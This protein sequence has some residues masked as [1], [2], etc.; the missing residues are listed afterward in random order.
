VPVRHTTRRGLSS[1]VVL[2]VVPFAVVSCADSGSPQSG[3]RPSPTRTHGSTAPSTT[4]TSSGTQEVTF[5][6]YSPQGALLGAF[7]VTQ[8]VSGSCITPG[9][10]GKSSYRCF[11]QP[12]SSVYDPC[13]APPHATSGPLVCVADPAQP[14]VTRFQ[15][16]ALPTTP[17]TGPVTKPWAMRLA[18]GQACI[19]VAAAWDG[20]GPFACPTPATSGTSEADCHQPTSGSPT[21]VTACQSDQ[22][23][24]SP[25]HPEQVVTIWK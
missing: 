4:T 20:L 19:L 8:T 24:S 16:G 25:F 6:P 3:S 1:L 12:G 7:N 23:P 15:V 14:A 17:T 2:L 21:W 13:F 18:N 9:V 22:E 5:E 10:A 11:A